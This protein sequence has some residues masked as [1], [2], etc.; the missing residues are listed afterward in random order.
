MQI[1]QRK[2]ML[3]YENRW[4]SVYF[5]H[6]E[7]DNPDITRYTRIVEADG[8]PGVAILPIFGESFG[9]V[10]VFRY[11]IG[12]ELLEIPRGF[13]EEDDPESDARRELFE[14]TGISDCK[15]VSLGQLYPNSG[16][17]SGQVNLFAA[18]CTDESIG[19]KPIDREVTEFEWIP[20]D[21]VEKLI[22]TDILDPF[23]LVAILRAKIANL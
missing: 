23:A 18:R 2:E 12:Q 22:P 1:H 16:L 4:I 11:P 19:T 10:R 7:C 21:K 6:V 8:K 9:F 14:E 13:G 5:D 17:L 3:V 20:R 15:M